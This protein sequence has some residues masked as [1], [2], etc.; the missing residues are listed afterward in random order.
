MAF[1]SRSLAFVAALGLVSA[2]Q[3]MAAITPVAL[4]PSAA[5]TAGSRHGQDVSIYGDTAVVG[6]PF[7]DASQTVTDAGTV[8]VY[9]RDSGTG[10]WSA[11]LELTA[12]I[13]TKEDLYGFSVAISG[14]TLVVAAPFADESGFLNAGAVYVYTRANATAPWTAPLRLTSSD[15]SANDQFG[16]SVALDGDTL[17]VGAVSGEAG[18]L[19]SGA[20]YVFYRVAGNWQQPPQRLTATDAA[21]GDFFGNAVAIAGDRLVIG[22]ERADASPSLLDSGAAYVF[23]RTANGWIEQSKL[24]PDAVDRHRSDNFGASVTVSGATVVVGQPFLGVGVGSNKGSATIFVENGG[25]WAKSATLV[26]SDGAADDYFGSD[27]AISDD[28]VV[29]GAYYDNFGTATSGI[30]AGSAYLFT[31]ATNGVWNQTSTYVAPTPAANALFGSAVAAWG[32][33]TLIG[34]PFQ[35]NASNPPV[36]VGSVYAFVLAEKPTLT[37]LDPMG[38][39]LVGATINLTA[40]V[41]DVN[42]AAITS[43]SVQ[44]FV[45]STAIGAPVALNNGVAASSTTAIS[46][47]T[48]AITARYLGDAAATPQPLLP[49]VSSVRSVEALRSTTTTDFTLLPAGPAFYGQALT[50]GVHVAGPTSGMVVFKD[51]G[52]LIGAPQPIDSSGNVQTIIDN[53]A[54][55]T[56]AHNIS[57]E[58]LG[59]DAFA[60]SVSSVASV[61]IQQAPV[62]LSL[63]TSPSPSVDGTDFSLIATLTAAASNTTLFSPSGRIVFYDD[64][65]GQTFL[66][67]PVVINGG[68][69]LIVS[70]RPVGSYSFHVTYNGDDNYQPALNAVASHSVLLGSDLA[71][72]KTNCD[73]VP[74]PGNCF[75]QSNSAP[76]YIIT[77]TNLGP[78]PVT[79]AQ[80][81]DNL[82]DGDGANP[83]DPL[84]PMFAQGASWSCVGLDGG[85]CGSIT[86]GSGDISLTLGVLPAP[87]NGVPASVEITVNSQLSLPGSEPEIMNEA[88]VAPPNDIA[89]TNSVNNSSSAVNETGLFAD[90]LE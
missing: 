80:V 37:T 76:I 46:A 56:T 48:L 49:S 4:P 7:S 28:R 64:T 14:N 70:G 79:G 51:G 90:G 58:F 53:L 13:R 18:V 32:G 81:I 41:K 24:Q 15:I 42:D 86:S 63:I 2:F 6:T 23:K 87:S 33:S 57:A 12:P 89:E 5:L 22:A 36:A 11:P 73:P 20:A 27:V 74:P 69:A 21:S 60:P 88:S 10:V 77:V 17:V 39:V 71:I 8:Y 25:T 67:N 30:D 31:R 43:G 50:F 47:G 9:T 72:T 44:F 55:E 62:T 29:V 35:A 66:A 38:D 26:A 82:H 65:S 78:N 54:T 84:P 1:G 83:L 16:H 52:N 59:N 68:A 61:T 75:L 45:G 85:D 3:V 19:D 40:R 34:A